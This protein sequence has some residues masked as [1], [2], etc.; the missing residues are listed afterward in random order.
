MDLSSNEGKDDRLQDDPHPL[1]SLHD[2]IVVTPALL[3][4]LHASNESKNDGGKTSCA[5]IVDQM[6]SKQG[7]EASPK[8]NPKP[9]MAT[10]SSAEQAAMTR[11]GMPLAT[12][13]PLWE[14]DI[15]LGMITAGDTAAK[16]N[17][18]MKPTVQGRPRTRLLRTATMI[19]STKQGM[20][21]ALTTIAESF[22]RATG[23][24]SRPAMRRITAR[25]IDRRVLLIAG[26]RSWP[27]YCGWQSS[28][29]SFCAFASS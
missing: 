12:P 13:K 15:K 19:A 5:V 24:S 29:F 21:V 25:Q 11:V 3:P 27:I 6:C 14:S 23:S 9:E 28:T 16:T 26:S 1:E 17:P 20:K 4:P 7:N 2:R 10:T 22:I 18:S 8:K